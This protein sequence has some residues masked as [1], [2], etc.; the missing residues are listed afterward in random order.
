MM[1][2]NTS[3]KRCIMTIMTI[4][5][6]GLG[7]IGAPALVLIGTSVGVSASKTT[8]LIPNSQ[9]VFSESIAV[10]IILINNCFLNL[11]LDMILSRRYHV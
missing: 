1:Q 2:K 10:A 6:F 11:T 8:A 5:K 9:Q 4:T 7:T 3:I